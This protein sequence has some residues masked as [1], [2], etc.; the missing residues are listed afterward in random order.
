MKVPLPGSHGTKDDR[1]AEHLRKRALG[2]DHLQFS[3]TIDTHDASAA[4]VEVSI[5]SPRHSSGTLTS[6]FMTGSTGMGIASPI[7]FLKAS[8][9]AILNA[10]SDEST[11]W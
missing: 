1:I 10:I 9:A 6:T 5:T 2:L 8:E 3:L 7:A 4:A 11:S